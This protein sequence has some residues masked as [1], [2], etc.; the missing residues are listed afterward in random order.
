MNSDRIKTP[1]RIGS[2]YADRI[3]F[4]DAVND[5][6]THGSSPP[7]KL[8]TTGFIARLFEAFFSA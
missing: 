7:N 5:K 4:L 8:Q 3:S 1:V 2:I 6:V